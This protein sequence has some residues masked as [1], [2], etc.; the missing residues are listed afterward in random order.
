MAPVN[1]LEQ[2]IIEQQLLASGKALPT[3]TTS[4][5]L[6]A[7]FAMAGTFP[8]L[9]LSDVLTPLGIDFIKESSKRQSSKQMGQALA[10]LQGWKGTATRPDPQNQDKWL[11]RIEQMA[12]GNIPSKVPV[13]VYQGDDDPT[14][15]PAATEAYVKVAKTAG[16]PIEYKHY[17]GVDHLRVPAAAL[18]DMMRWIGDRFSGKQP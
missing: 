6:M 14:I 3:M 12:L 17:P 7:Q 16:T 8:E 4:E 15:F 10:Y 18:A 9:Q 5:T 13:A 11:K 2:S 1:A